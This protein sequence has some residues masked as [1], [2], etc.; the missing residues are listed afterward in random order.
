MSRAH[1]H[2]AAAALLGALALFVTGC[3]ADNSDFV[4][5][6]QASSPDQLIGGD[7]AM[8]RVGDFIL[9]NDKVRIAILNKD[10]SP[11][12]GVFGGTFVDADLQRPQADFRN[13]TGQDQLAEVIPV[14][15]LLW[16]RPD[17]DDVRVINDGSDGEAAIV[18][19]SGETGVFL[20]AL[21]V[22]KGD[23]LKT[24]FPNAK[25]ELRIETDYILEPGKSYVRIKSRAYRTDVD[26]LPTDADILPLPNLTE[27][28]PIFTAALG[29]TAKQLDSGV[30]AGDFLFF[31]ARNDIFAPGIGYDEEKPI[32]D[33]LFQGRD[34]FTFPL[35]FDFMGASGGAVSYGYFSA[36]PA[37]E[38]DPKVLVPIITSSSTGFVTSAINCSTNADDDDTCDRFA[39]WEW[40]RFFA[41]GQ[42]D[43]ASISD[44][45][46]EVRGTATGVIKGVAFGGNGQP[47]ANGRLF[48]FRAPDAGG[49]YADVYALVD[50]NIDETGTPGLMNVIEADVGDDPV[51]DGAFQATMPPGTYW[52]VATNADQTSTSEPV[53]F[54]LAAGGNAILAPVVPQPARVRFRVVDETGAL[55]EAK[56]S[57]VSKDASGELLE[58]DGLRRPYMGQGRL[59]NGLRFLANTATGEGVVEVEAGRYDLVVSRGPEYSIAR[60]DLNLAP[61]EEAQPSIV[62]R[63]EVDT[64]GYI[65][66]DFHLHAEASFDSGMP[67]EKRVISAVVEGL[68]LA[69]STDHD[70]VAD[71]GPA[72]RELGLQDR[73]QTGIG[74]EMST[75][76]LGHFIAF[77]LEYNVNDIP[78][79]GAP[80][81]T[82]LDGPDLTSEIASKIQ[83]GEQ[84][85]RIIA[86]PRDGFIGH[87]SQV[88]LDPYDFTRELDF[89]EA[90]NVLLARSTCDFEAM[91]VFN[92]K[93]F[94]LVRTPTNEEVVLFNR[95]EDRIDE[96]EDLAAL[97]DACPELS[98]G[99]PLTTCD[100]G[101]RFFE[102]KQRFRRQLAFITARDILIRTPEEQLANW[103]FTPAGNSE[104]DCEA[105]DIDADVAK[106]PCVYHDGTYDDWLRWLDRGLAITITGASDSH[107]AAREPGMPRT[108]VQDAAELP[109]DIDV[110]AVAEKLGDGRALASFGPFIEASI[111]GETYGDTATVSGEFDLDLRVQTASW[112]GVDRIEVYVSGLL[113]EVIEL[114]HGP[115]PIVDFEGTLRLTAPATDGF[116]AIVALGF[117]EEN[118]LSPVSLD[119]AFG[120]LQLP[121][122]AALA[123]GA[124]PAFAVIF[125][126]SPTVPDF[127][128]VFPMAVTNAIFLDT[129]GDGSWKPEKALPAFCEQSCDPTAEDANDVCSEGLICL[130]TG[131]CGLSVTGKCTTGAPGSERRASQFIE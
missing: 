42:G 101:L 25:F 48:I 56:L 110:G 123:F 67:F 100:P 21:S 69:V 65:G 103:T 121:R 72:V 115:E 95:C 32:F 43:I 89:L 77:P 126:E 130:P 96:A 7:V 68:D 71:Y 88:G 87:I 64:T 60:I 24:L 119:V 111:N 16:P 38:P 20:E 50:A 86:H 80:D 58:R 116:V 5:A 23:L 83:A 35:A 112:Y 131:Q 49:D 74:V 82:C 78:D 61:G 53:R 10:S 106:L 8:A 41:I 4:R 91:E 29:D 57:F 18:R 128:P 73:I 30:L 47:L 54:N 17:V 15:N 63:R 28:L 118:L 102:C 12:P 81:W 19:V 52:A 76:E 45:I 113:E 98:P 75:L 127:F 94:D 14:V 129:D 22:L 13:G 114:D 70:I 120:E 125:S 117:R 124:I 62:L 84:G 93:R 31:G 27:S 59:G 3:T 122:V 90:N 26:P 99:G 6:Y 79:H 55:T 109:K 107:G 34:T 97:D 11:A 33:A 36:N 105:G 85:V 2:L 37:G 104:G 9:E 46:Y 44:I 51:E 66:G 108:Y 1:T 92:S 39:A 40:E